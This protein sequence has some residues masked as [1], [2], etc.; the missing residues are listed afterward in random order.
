M[1]Q[2]TYNDCKP[3]LDNGDALADIADDLSKITARPILA[4]D[5]R[6]FLVEEDLLFDGYDG[7][8]GTLQAAYDDATLPAQPGNQ[9]AIELLW[10]AA[11]QRGR[12]DCATTTQLRP[13]GI[14]RSFQEGGRLVSALGRFANQ[15]THMSPSQVDSFLALGGGL[16]YPDGVTAL[17]VQA[18][19]DQQAADVAEQTRKDS[20]EALR[21]DIENTYLN[22]AIADGVSTVADVAAAIK[23]GL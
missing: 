6:K 17:E 8:G 19:I 2:P 14:A 23:A 9:K 4:D 5:A 15:G 22:P 11:V 21:A 20:I 18:A 1:T 12:A 3:Y 7:P 16:K 13:N 10:V